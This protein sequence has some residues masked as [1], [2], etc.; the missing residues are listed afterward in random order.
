MRLSVLIVSAGRYDSWPTGQ[1]G[2]AHLRAMSVQRASGTQRGQEKVRQMREPNRYSSPSHLGCA[3][4]GMGHWGCAGLPMKG[5]RVV[6]GAG[7]PM[8]TC[9]KA[10]EIKAL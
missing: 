10:A 6:V 5:A 8:T 2:R 9:A 7:L 1:A 3:H 4:G